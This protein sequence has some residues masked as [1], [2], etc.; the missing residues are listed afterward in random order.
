MKFYIECC[1]SKEKGTI[2]FVLKV[3]FGY[4]VGVLTMEQDI[5]CELAD[6]KMSELYKMKPG[7]TRL[8]KIGSVA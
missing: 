7:D 2:Y 1:K 5:M 4:R 3:D 6:I 8:V